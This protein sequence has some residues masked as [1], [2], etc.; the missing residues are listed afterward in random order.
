[1]ADESESDSSATTVRPEPKAAG[2]APVEHII[3][4][5]K[6]AVATVPFAGGLASLLSDYI[7]YARARRLEEFAQQTVEE[8]GRL[9][10]RVDQ[11]YLHT[12]DFA[13]MFEKCF[14]AAA[15]NPQQEKLAAFH[16]ILVNSTTRRDLS[17]EEKE[18]F[19]NLALRLTTLH[20]RI[21][22]FME[23][24]EAYLSANGIPKEQ[25][26]GG[27]RQFFPTAIPGV[28]LD[29]IKSAFGDLYREGLLNTDASIFTTMTSGRGLDLLTGRV[30]DFGARFVSFISRAA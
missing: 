9:Q 13:F 24:P 20:I 14:R 21:L 8:L 4:V 17:E 1:M 19:L 18:Y 7:P 29:V 16:S 22:R 26:T 30:S 28:A 3:N 10:D 12:D 27:F 2:R 11:N 15:E 23:E 25:I 5:F 6:A